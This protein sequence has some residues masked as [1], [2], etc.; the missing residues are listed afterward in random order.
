MKLGWNGLVSIGGGLAISLL[1]GM[2]EAI[3][4]D[5]VV[6]TYGFI[7]MNIP[8]EDLATFAESGET[9]SELD[10]LLVLAGQDQDVLR[11]TL[12]EPISLSPTILDFTL[13]SPPGEW[14][15]DR[16][17]ESIHPASGEAGT[18]AL[19]SA[20]VGASADDSEITLLE[21][22]QVYPSSDI[23][24]RGDRLIETYSQ[25]YDMLEPLADLADIIKTIED[26]L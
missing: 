26:S 3:A 22:M 5:R 14:M 21:V 23:V 10:A 13:N 16:I 9:S 1:A 7:S 25:L 2:G 11:S 20:L 12:N 6:L 4:A 18:L 8:M 24:V 17:S 19:R 15:L